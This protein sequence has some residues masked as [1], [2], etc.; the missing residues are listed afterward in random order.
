MINGKRCR[1][2][3]E[4]NDDGFCSKCSEQEDEKDED[5]RCGMC[6][7]NEPVPANIATEN[8]SADVDMKIQCDWCD[9]WFHASCTGTQD[10]VDYI[11]REPPAGE[12]ISN[13]GLAVH[14][15]FCAICVSEKSN[16]LCDLKNSLK[17]A[18]T[19]Q[20]DK[21]HQ[22]LETADTARTS[23]TSTTSTSKEQ[24]TPT[25]N[26]NESAATTQICSYYKK[27]ICQHG[28]SG[29][30]LV[31]GKDCSY[32]HPKKC[33]KFCRYG[34]DR[35][36]GCAGSCGSFHPTLCRNSVQHKKCLSPNCTF[37]HLAG[38]QRY[39]TYEEQV[40]NWQPRQDS[41]TYNRERKVH[42]HTQHGWRQSHNG[43]HFKRR[44][45][46]SGAHRAMSYQDQ[47]PPLRSAQDSK[48]SEMSKAIEK[49]QQ[50]IQF[51]L[52]SSANNPHH[53][54]HYC[55]NANEAENNIPQQEFS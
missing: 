47:F 38:T 18:F 9:E 49:M 44:N 41:S 25:A 4:L 3:K 22:V 10:Y 52:S 6:Q 14:L 54:Q 12:G 36:N 8:S 11:G 43:L 28:K 1:K 34:E 55:S 29:K 32:L 27:G 39:A 16:I 50:N 33:I 40:F 23:T 46:P 20:K 30:K 21:S 51:L 7:D 5:E 48:L 19:P 13:G 37:T 15:W 2:W 17:K 42:F 45:E 26:K 35:V 53:T 24:A 31:N